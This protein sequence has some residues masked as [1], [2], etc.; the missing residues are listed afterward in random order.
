[1]KRDTG[2]IAVYTAEYTVE[3]LLTAGGTIDFH[4]STLDLPPMLRFGQ[5]DHVQRYVTRVW[6]LQDS[7]VSSHPA[8]RVRTRRG[9][10]KAHY[11]VR[12]HEIA[13]PMADWSMTNVTVLH[14]LAHAITIIRHGVRVAAHGEEFRREFVTLVRE[15]FSPEAALLLQDGFTLELGLTPAH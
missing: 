14:E 11:S 2:R 13:L 9:Q 12:E 10:S 7:D 4:G 3:E 5:F 6:E 8:P 1:M 15:C